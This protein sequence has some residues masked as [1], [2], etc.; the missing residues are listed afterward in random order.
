M[1]SVPTFCLVGAWQHGLVLDD[2]VAARAAFDAAEKA[3]ADA[4]QQVSDARAKVPD[5]RRKLH[6]QIIAAAKSGARQIDIVKASGYQ[7]EHIRQIL[8][9]AGVEAAE[10]E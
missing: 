10:G 9:A 4:Q 7:R 5:A 1:V 2:L 3:V 6:A 8:K